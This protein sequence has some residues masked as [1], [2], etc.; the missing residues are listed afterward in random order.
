MTSTQFAE[1]KAM[2]VGAVGGGGCSCLNYCN[3]MHR[4]LGAT[5]GC[6]DKN[7]QGIFTLNH[8]QL[9]Q[10]LQCRIGCFCDC[11]TSSNGDDTCVLTDQGLGWPKPV[12]PAISWPGAPAE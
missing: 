1:Y 10:P 7:P 3:Y 6:H 9:A 12:D 4:P 8:P 5:A 11:G 2:I